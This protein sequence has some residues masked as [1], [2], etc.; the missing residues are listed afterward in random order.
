MT[1]LVDLAPWPTSRMF[2]DNNVVAHLAVMAYLKLRR[3]LPALN[4]AWIAASAPKAGELRELFL[5]T[6]QAAYAE[7]AVV[8]LL[9]AGGGRRAVYDTYP[10]DGDDL[11]VHVDRLTDRLE[12]WLITLGLDP[13]AVLTAHDAA[14]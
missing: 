13:E 2:A 14:S 7:T 10:A 11:G 9:M 6:Q 4:A 8:Q 12:G 1:D 3:D 5:A